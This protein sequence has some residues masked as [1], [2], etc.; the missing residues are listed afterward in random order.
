MKD[1][2]QSHLGFTLIELLVVVLIIGILAAIALPQYQVAVGKARFMQALTAGEAVKKAEELFYLANGRY[3]N[4]WDELGIDFSGWEINEN[5]DPSSSRVKNGGGAYVTVK[6]ATNDKGYAY[7][8]AYMGRKESSNIPTST[9]LV[10]LDQNSK[11]PGV[12]TCRAMGPDGDPQRALKEK[13]CKALGGVPME[14]GEG[15]NYSYPVY[16]LP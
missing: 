6:Y 10:Y 3:T 8:M 5:L 9:Y 4:Q 1:A 13:I 14:K 11:L 15:S 12:R 7:V 16:E 2:L